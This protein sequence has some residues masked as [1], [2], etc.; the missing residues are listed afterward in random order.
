MNERILKLMGVG[1]VMM[2][3]VGFAGSMCCPECQVG[4][5]KVAQYAALAPYMALI[6]ALVALAFAFYFYKKMLTAPAG[7][8][9]MIEIAQHVREGAFAYLKRQYKV[10]AVVFVILVAIF[11]VLAKYDIQ[12]PFVPVAFL[13][14]GFFSG[15][16]GF[17]GMNTAT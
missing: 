3:A 12:N 6:C 11:A 5:S 14:G 8:P 7:T 16:C 2:S 1:V 15:L 10:V 17:L 9:L 13:T 4:G